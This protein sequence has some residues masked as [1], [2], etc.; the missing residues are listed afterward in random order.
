M[1]S[2]NET[3][4]VGHFVESMLH[5]I[6]SS[7]SQHTN[8]DAPAVLYPVEHHV[9][10]AAIERKEEEQLRPVSRRPETCVIVSLIDA[11]ERGSAQ[12]HVDGIGRLQP[13]TSHVEHVTV[14]L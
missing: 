11:L 2:R 4:K 3:D 8:Q 5:S 13:V 7:V 9:D 1:A 6:L 14:L 12:A 10:T